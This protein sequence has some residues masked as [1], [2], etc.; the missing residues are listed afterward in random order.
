VVPPLSPLFRYSSFADTTSWNSQQPVQYR[1]GERERGR[2]EE[3]KRGREGERERGRE[4]EREGESF[5]LRSYVISHRFCVG[6]E[7]GR[8]ITTDE[9]GLRF[10]VKV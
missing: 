5:L 4:G 2:E 3:R 1:E 7:G 6:G 10:R 8:I 9:K